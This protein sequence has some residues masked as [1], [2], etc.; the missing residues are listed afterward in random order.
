MGGGPGHPWE[1]ALYPT[2]LASYLALVQT[3]GG[4]LKMS[5]IHDFTPFFDPICDPDSETRVL[6]SEV[7][8]IC[9][10]LCQTENGSLNRAF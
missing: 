9:T 1:G 6:F 5:E 4:G 7:P 10:D 3:S 2:T 8:C